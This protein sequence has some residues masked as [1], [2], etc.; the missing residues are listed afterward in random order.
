MVRYPDAQYET[1]SLLSEAERQKLLVEWNG[2]A[3]ESPRETLV[4]LF[5]AQAASTPD[6][7]AVIFGHEELNYASLN[8]RANRLAH[9]LVRM[10]VGPESLVGIALEPSTET[11][12]SVLAAMKAGAAYLPLDPHYPQ[13]RLEHMLSDAAPAVVIVKGQVPQI[14]TGKIINLNGATLE[15][16]ISSSPTHNPTDAERVSPLLPQ[17]SAYVIYTSGSTGLPKGVVVTHAGLPAL[18]EAQKRFNITQQSRVLQF[19]SLNFDASL[20]EIVMALTCGA[21][22]VLIEGERS[23]A[24]LLDTLVT[25]GVTHAL[26][27]LGVLA[28]LEEFQGLPLECLIN[29]GEALPESVVTRW[30]QDRRIFNAYGPTEATVYATASTALYGAEEAP[31]IG[32]PIRNT[33]VYVLNSY[34]ELAPAGVIGELYIAGPRLARGYLKRPEL[35]AERFIADPFGPSG[36]RMYRTGDLARWRSDGN[37]EFVGRAD[38]Q[39]KIRGFRIE[40]GEIEA[41]LLQHP[42]V[43][44]AAVIVREEQQAKRRLV[45]YV[46]RNENGQKSSGRILR[47]YLRSRLPE[48]MVPW[49]ILELERLPLTPNGKLDRRALARIVPEQR[50]ERTY[51]APRTPY[52]EVLAK[53]W[54]ELLQVKQVGIHDNFFEIGGHSLLTLQLTSRIRLAFAIELPV[55]ALFKAPTVAR[56]AEH[57]ESVKGQ[58]QSQPSS[59]LVAIQPNGS[60]APFFCVHPVG[61]HVVCY[62]ELAKQLGSEQPFYGLQSPPVDEAV[63]TTMSIEEMARLYCQEVLRVQRRRPLFAGW[64]VHGR[65]HCF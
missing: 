14:A 33:R 20:W 41:V 27:P 46:V 52:E 21:T 18:T 62:M 26:L 59:I 17:H 5:E 49:P 30:S 7:A 25:H 43:A 4:E 55:S 48:Y 34:L 9:Y 53:I 8:E 1:A 63:G 24:L 37:L 56:M 6:L 19:A 57:I 2:T 36:T 22:L 39:V 23:G 3:V 12:V 64:L 40:L 42:A 11:V 35:T 47:E 50:D 54:A 65:M 61:G 45:G 10:G 38:E 31:P 28:T 15:T 44:Q 29:G 60:L 16:Q 32:A 13:A 58:E 51:V